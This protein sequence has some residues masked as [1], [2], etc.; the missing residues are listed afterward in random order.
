VIGFDGLQL[1]ALMEPPL[2]SVALDT[3]RLG[4]LA[5]E[6]VGRLLTGDDPLPPEDLEVRAELRL[7][8]SA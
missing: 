8:G 6:Q 3:L 5:V 7:A 4:S 2:S 1:G